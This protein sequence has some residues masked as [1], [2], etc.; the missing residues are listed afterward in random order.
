[1]RSPMK[2]IFIIVSSSLLTLAP[3]KA[4]AWD[5]MD[6]NNY[7]CQPYVGVDAQWR[8]T[9]PVIGYGNNLFKRHYLQGNLYLG[10][11]VCDYLGLE[12][13]Y[14][15]TPTRNKTTTVEGGDV[16]GIR[17]SPTEVH[18]SKSRMQG[19]HAGIMG[20]YPVCNLLPNTLFRN[21]LELLAYVGHLRLN[22][23]Y[24]DIVAIRQN[25]PVNVRM[26]TRTFDGTK[27]LLRVGLGAQ[28]TYCTS[29][30]RFMVGYESTNQF[31]NEL[32][33]EFGTASNMRL[34]LNNSL[35]VSLG[36]FVTIP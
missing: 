35:F 31:R 15:I 20:F 26:T 18:I 34:K 6:A 2:N 36:I 32:S 27:S 30:I 21:P 29:G 1:M 13:G 17:S 19:W 8:I 4:L 24:Q 11:K 12:F 22:T 25:Q 5:P 28:Y 7:F 3:L 14:Q 10:F 23:Y 33:K 16:L 9:Q